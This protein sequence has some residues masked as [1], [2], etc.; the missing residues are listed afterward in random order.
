MVASYLLAGSYGPFGLLEAD[1][2]ALPEV[3]HIDDLLD[4]SCEDIGGPIVG[5]LSGASVESCVNAGERS[6][7]SSLEAKSELQEAPIEDVEVK[8]DLCVPVS[9]NCGQCEL[10]CMIRTC[11]ELK[12]SRKCFL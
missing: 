7:S 6:I 5:G 11:I 4:F 10:S 2:P 8:T 9:L 1:K 12:I 3:F